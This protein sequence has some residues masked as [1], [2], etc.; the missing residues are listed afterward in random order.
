MTAIAERAV[1]RVLAAA[2]RD[3][4]RFGEV[5]LFR[6]EAGAF[7]R[8]VAKR[9]AFGPA[10]RAPPEGAWPGR[11]NK[12]KPLGNNRF[13]HGGCS[14]SSPISLGNHFIVTFHWQRAPLGLEHFHK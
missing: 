6:P 13:A 1:L 9:L 12:W 8:A 7:V 5:H 11:L 2:P 3:G 10:A 4:F 14:I